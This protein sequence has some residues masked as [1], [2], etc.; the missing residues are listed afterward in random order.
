MLDAKRGSESHLSSVNMKPQPTGC[1]RAR[2]WIRKD[3]SVNGNMY[4]E[5]C[6]R[7]QSAECMLCWL[8]FFNSLTQF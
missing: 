2:F 3:C 6:F 8:A 4:R 7:V 1:S 5:R